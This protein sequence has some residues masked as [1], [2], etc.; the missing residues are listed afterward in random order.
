VALRSLGGAALPALLQ[1]LNDARPE[2]AAAAAELLGDLRREEVVRPLL[3][4]LKYAKRPVQL[5]AGRALGRCGAVAVPALREALTEE[6]PWVRRQIEQALEVA[7][8]GSTP[9]GGEAP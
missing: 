3:V 9:D 5:A 7:E 4:A 1:G 2:V 8:S 6:Q